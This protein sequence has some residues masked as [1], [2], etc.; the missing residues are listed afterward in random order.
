MA[1]TSDERIRR[2]F[3]A[4]Q[5]HHSGAGDIEIQWPDEHIA[6]FSV[7]MVSPRGPSSV[8]RVSSDGVVVTTR[9]G[10]LHGDAGESE[11]V[12]TL[13]ID[14]SQDFSWDNVRSESADELAQLLVKHMRRRMRESD[15]EPNTKERQAV[16]H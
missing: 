4:F 1:R 13:G 7:R 9:S 6:G 5:R 2:L 11:I 15:P 10:G 8:L 14:L 16:Q 3:A 12:D